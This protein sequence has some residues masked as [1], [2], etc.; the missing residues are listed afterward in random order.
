MVDNKRKPIII[1]RH[2]IKSFIKRSNYKHFTDVYDLLINVYKESLP[3]IRPSGEVHR[4]SRCGKWRLV[5]SENEKSVFVLTV[6]EVPFGN[7]FKP[8]RRKW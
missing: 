5:I 7:K 2:A 8:R 4:R 6:Y 1:T 3:E